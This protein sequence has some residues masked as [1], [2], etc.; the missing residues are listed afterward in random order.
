VVQLKSREIAI[1]EYV[2]DLKSVPGLSSV[3]F[4]LQSGLTIGALATI[5]S[6]AES[7]EAQKYFPALVQAA[8]SMA[9]PQV[10]NKGT[11]VGNIC[12]AVPS[13]D[14]APPLLALNATLRLKSLA[15]ERTVPIKEFFTGPRKTVLQPD[16]MVLEINVPTPPLG[17]SSVYLK[18]SPRHS[19]DLAIVGVAVCGIM[20][21]GIC[22]DVT[23]ALGAVAPTPIRAHLAEEMLKNNKITP[24]LIEDAA[25]NAITQCS[26]IDDH[27]A[28]KE[29]RC[30][31]VRVMT[32][33][34]LTQ[35]LIGG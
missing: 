7:S 10:R 26:P 20:N 8:L 9:S 17:S 1:P 6:V 14:S 35:V 15:G 25:Q 11:F 22:Q 33:R 16:E 18:L 24:E 13:A 19:M 5:S 30:D 28:S 2:L 34:A 3:T 32:K 21:N 29:Y 27:R 31:M 23:I 12:N 4:N